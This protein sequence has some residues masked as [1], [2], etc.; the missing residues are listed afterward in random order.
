MKLIY[1]VFIE[2]SRQ[3][4]QQLATNRL[5]SFLSLL[6]ISIGI[7]CVIGVFAG[8]ESLQTFIRKNLEQ[9]GDDIL[10]VQKWPFAEPNLKW[11]EIMKRP[12]PSYDDYEVIKEKVNGA[13]LVGYYTVIGVKTLKYQSSYVERV[14]LIAASEEVSELFQ[15]EFDKGRFYSPAEV[16][17]GANKVVLGYDVTESLFGDLEPIGKNIK[18]MGRKYEVIG[19]LAKVGDDDFDPLDYDETAI[20]I[21]NN[22]RNLVN[23]KSRYTFDGTVPVKAKDGVPLS[24][25]GDEIR[26]AL[27]S[28]RRLKPKEDDDFALNELAM[29]MNVVNDFFGTLNLL[30]FV[31][32]GFAMLVGGVSVANIMFVSVKERTNLIGVKKA[33]GAKKYMI[34]LEFLLEAIWLCLI[35]GAV[36]LLLVFILAT[37]MSNVL[38]FELFLSFGNISIGV[39]FSVLVGIIAGFVP[40]LQAARL[41]PVVAMRQA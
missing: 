36:G 11:W 24:Y 9:L 7:F 32:G 10:Y 3:A 13:S 20:L 22:A 6:G 19:V 34:L 12:Q 1:R 26:G 28:H 35:G 25:L 27:R 4:Y 30:G 39:V 29:I 16:Q 15:F 2:S 8:V 37:V 31:I 33:I 38:D 23:L 17:Y 18:I 40:A 41:D 14:A 21:Y 5:R